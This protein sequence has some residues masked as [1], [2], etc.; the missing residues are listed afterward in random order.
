MKAHLK[1]IL[2]MAISGA[3]IWLFLPE[4][5]AVNMP[6]TLAHSLSE[7]ETIDRL[8]VP[9]GFSITLYSDNLS[10]ARALAITETGDIIV[11]RPNIGQLTLI[12]KDNDNDGKSDGE[13]L[14]V[15]N[16]NKPHGI[17]LHN[18]WLYI[19]ET[20]AVL[21]I[22]YNA[23]ERKF[24]GIPHY[25]I[26]NSFPG[27]GNHW[28]RGLKIGPDEKLYV[29]VG[30]SCNACIEDTQKR[31]SILRYDL[32]GKNEVLFARGLRNT[33]GF[34]WQKTTQL[35][36]GVDNGRDFLGDNQPPEELN[37]INLGHH[38]GWP[39]KYGNNINDSEFS[40]VSPSGL[41]MTKPHH[42]ITAHSAPLS[43]LFTQYNINLRN[44]ALV[45]LHGSWNRS[46]KSG[47]KVIKLNFSAD[48]NISQQDFLTGFEHNGVVIGRP[49]DLAEDKHGNIYLSDDYIGR[50]YKISP[51][52]KH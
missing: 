16:L 37:Q 44:S 11:S 15:G 46:E 40:K 6:I 7:Q 25:I 39:Y 48:N 50:I 12:Y 3:L 27:G 10:D 42:Q 41:T 21:R 26:R 51:I 17:T 47:Y 22:K 38:Y 18:G 23:A 4:K 31:G 33:T 32:D 34:D 28:V 2:Y 9:D 8:Q 29:S 20:N 36:F 24:I 13:K 45:S 19:A 14:L 30:S 1:S 49:V 35:M 5:Y 43:I 52:K